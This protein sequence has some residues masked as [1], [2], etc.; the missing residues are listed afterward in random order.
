MG[1]AADLFFRT[2]DPEN[3]LDYRV[4]PSD[5]QYDAQRD[6]WNDLA[7]HL[8]EDLS[9][10]SG[11]AIAT[12]LQGSYKYGT[13]VRPSNL[14]AEF[15]VDLGV[16]FRWQGEPDDGGYS[17]QE[18][19]QLVHLS[20]HEYV[21][22]GG[23]EADNVSP[24]KNR[25]ERVHF[26]SDFHIDVP[27][28]HL[29]EARDAR[30]LAT[31]ENGWEGS[32]P[33]AIYV[34]W[35]NTIS[36]AVRPRARRLVR[37]FKMWAALRLAEEARPS[38]IML[39]VL[40]AEA[41]AA[42]DASTLS[43]DDEYFRVVV[44]SILNRLQQSPNVPNPVDKKE[45]LNRLSTEANDDLVEALDALLAI[46]ER[47][48]AVP[49]KSEAADI[50]TEAFDHFFPVPEEEE[51]VEALSRA[52][53]TI[54]FVPEV[55]IEATVGSHTLSG[56]NRIGPIPKGSDLTF[57][58][59]NAARLPIGATVSWTVRNSGDEAEQENDLGHRNTSSNTVTETTA[60]RGSHFMDVAVHLN[61]RLI[62]R[63]RVPVTVSS[64]GVP[65]RNPKRPAWTQLRR[66]RR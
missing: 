13:Q 28:Y 30:S 29:D 4:R 17:T 58:L 12:W 51:I 5:E 16:Y 20:L 47:A 50:W 6:R 3:C 60:Y 1:D 63:R 56:I 31:E 27:A 26:L 39:T 49:S 37:Y 10:R 61:G 64:M 41:F 45:D 23:N 38:S 40:V 19:K 65:K 48:L 24:P 42:V 8:K 14:E 57:T 44:S 21:A 36:A 66:G 55:A 25:C 54:Q 9:N 62:G 43:G 22:D 2:D 18:L 7:E 11:Y 46:A 33:K 32:D 52:L 35:K 53:A 59:M 15:D 34:W